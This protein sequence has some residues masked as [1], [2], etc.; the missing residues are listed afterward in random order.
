[1]IHAMLFDLI[2]SMMLLSFLFDKMIY[3]VHCLLLSVECCCLCSFVL[4][5]GC[6]LLLKPSFKY[7]MPYNSKLIGRLDLSLNFQTFRKQKPNILTSQ[8]KSNK[9]PKSS[10][11]TPNVVSFSL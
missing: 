9:L 1:M 11:S 8:T 2:G 5:A 4:L 3:M 6:K 10:E 7:A